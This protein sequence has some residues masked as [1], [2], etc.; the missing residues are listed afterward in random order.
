MRSP[1]SAKILFLILSMVSCFI[2]IGCELENNLKEIVS[3][4]TATSNQTIGCTAGW[5]CS[6]ENYKIYVLENCTRTEVTKCDRGCDNSTCRA[7][8]V[9]TVGFKCIDS[10]RRAYQAEDCSWV[11]KKKCDWGCEEGKCKEQPANLTNTTTDSA[12]P[13]VPEKSSYSAIAEN[14]EET[15]TEPQT[16]YTLKV[17]E[18]Q[19]LEMNGAVRNVSIHFLEPTQVMLSVNGI[20]S[21]W[22]PEGGSFNY[23]NIG[24]EFNIEWILFQSF[25]GGKQE[26][27]FSIRLI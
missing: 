3:N 7:A 23:E 1:V 6:D 15:V 11:N 18:Q 4:E 24:V 14:Q 21:D 12:S 10:E 9:C 5:E 16:I 19:Q 26:I 22:I 13:A 27:G 17:G 25:A 2:L 8:L 20:K